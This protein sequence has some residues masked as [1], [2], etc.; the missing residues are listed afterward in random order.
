[1][2]L[3]A[4]SHG[5]EYEGPIALMRLAA[6]LTPEEVTGR[7]IILPTMNH[8]AV[9]AATRLSPID[10]LNMNR[11]FPGRYDGTQTQ[12]IAH[13]VRTRLVARA[14]VVADFHSGGKTLDFVPSAVMHRL[15]D[16][17]LM[18]RT[19]DAVAAFG[20]PLG[21]VLTELDSEGML[22]TEVERAGKIFLSTELGGAGTAS[23]RTIGIAA[24]GAANLLRHFGVLAGAVEAPPEPTHLMHTPDGGFVAADGAGMLEMLVDLGATVTA[25]QPLARIHAFEDHGIEPTLYRAPCEGV[26]YCRHVPGLVAR[27]DCLA[28][29]AQDLP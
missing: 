18:R 24:R 10:G 22:D 2:L 7:V 20:A 1:V 23:P 29:I 12:M 28:V 25:G 6:A 15:D 19:L 13:W 14:D 21:L 5:D 26:L 9:R 3:T 27:G 8:P 4:G 11:V 16:P 17:A